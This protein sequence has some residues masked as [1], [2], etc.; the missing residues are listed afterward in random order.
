MDLLEWWLRGYDWFLGGGLILPAFRQMDRGM[1]A[2]VAQVLPVFWLVAVIPGREVTTRSGV[3][4]WDP[5]YNVALAPYLAL[6]EAVVLY[7]AANGGLESWLAYWTWLGV[8]AAIAVVAVNQVLEHLPKL[9]SP[10]DS[11]QSESWGTARPTWTANAT[12]KVE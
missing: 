1:C 12:S 7:G 3:R 5:F 9:A 10:T 4:I 8:I 2:L 6:M 11:S